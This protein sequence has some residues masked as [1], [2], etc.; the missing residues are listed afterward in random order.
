[1]KIVIRLR[2]HFR[3]RVRFYTTWEDLKTAATDAWRKVCLVP[4][5]I[6]SVCADTALRAD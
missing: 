2:H 1:V 4:E 6:T 3:A 5:F